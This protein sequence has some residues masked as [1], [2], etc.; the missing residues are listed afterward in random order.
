MRKLLG[1]ILILS[2]VILTNAVP[3]HAVNSRINWTE[4]ELAFIEEHPVIR[5]GI[6]PQF[7]PFEF[8]DKDG[9]YKGITADYLS[10]IQERTGIQF[11]V[12]KGLTWPEAYDM[13]LS[14]GIDVLPAVSK[15]TERE[16]YFLFSDPYYYFKRVIVTR[17]TDTEISGIEDLESQTIAVQRNSSHHSYLLSYPK[18]NLSLYDS[19]ETALTAVANGT[20]RAFVGNLAT[21]NYLI[22]SNGLTNLKF[23]AFEAEKQQALYFAVR[24]DWP[25]LVGILNKAMDTVTEEEKLS[26]HSKWIDLKQE[27]DYGPMI[28]IVSIIGALVAVVMT[29]SFYWIIRLRKEVR[30][31]ERVQRDLEKAK[32]EA[33]E[34]NE[35]K[36]SFMAR[37]SHEIRTPL[38]A[39][40][41]MAYLLKKTEVS[42][43]QKMYI[44]RITQA[45]TNML[46][47]IND[48]LDFSKIEAG[49]VELEIT[50]F[51]MD[52]VI[53]DVV[54]I[55][56]YKIEEQQIGFK[57]SKDPLVPNWFYGDSKRIEQ[58]LLNILNNAAKF[59]ST[60]EVSLEL[61]LVAK[62][63]EKY[64]LSFSV[65]DTGIG[66]TKEQV[67]KLFEPFTQG[68][69]SINRRFG[70]S[71]LGLSIVKNLVDMMG[72]QI[73]V[74]ST[75]G[76]GS[77]FILHLTLTIDKEKQDEYVKTVSADHF[78][79]VRTLI[80]EKAG[81]SMNLMES[82][83]RALG[84]QCELT[85]S[86]AS[87][88]SML[89]AADGKFAKPFDLLIVDYETPSQGGFQ[90]LESIRNNN[91]IV[92][93]PKTI[94]LLPMMREDLFDR[95]D[96]Y[97]IDIGIGKPIIPSILLNGILDLFSLKAV[98]SQPSENMGVYP[99]KTDKPYTV[100]V[101]EDNKTNQ[102]IAKS[103][104]QQAGM[105][106][107]Q[108]SDGKAAIDLYNPTQ[109]NIDLILMDLHM[110]VMNGYDAA[111]EIRK[112]SAHIP[113]VAMTADVILGVREKCEQSGIHYY[114]S[115]PFDPDRF[116]Q[117]IHEILMKTEDT[118]QA[119][120]ILDQSAGL[121][122]MGGEPKV[123]QQILQEYLEEN[124]ETPKRLS[125]AVFEKRYSDA[126]QII[127]K[128]KSSTGSI[129]AKTLHEI[130]VKLQ[131]ALEHREESEI[132]LLLK[133]FSNMFIRLLEEITA[134][135]GQ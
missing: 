35:F 37:M 73:Q 62:E 106:V 130:S 11:E 94:M 8:I 122:N 66:M 75:P 53:Q 50:S 42:L 19:V 44:D 36:S 112:I 46:S 16:Q 48:I 33:D 102:L 56:S 39:I 30:M 68:D 15:T 43:T 120:P 51:S 121:R 41:G 22:R 111:K 123:Y 52:Q 6:D 79:S 126:A 115:K 88:L 78:K 3:C 96:E 20:E 125:L 63:N 12:V 26:I 134:Y 89:E 108:A 85:T 77:T 118:A 92:K 113:I 97:G 14:G 133:E 71:G 70:G 60:G 18:T 110:P 45:S 67:D 83:L 72:G 104:L 57:L 87:A 54:N 61:R 90:F 9:E 1:L 17:D 124:G 91:S 84:I 31:R 127:H 58:I 65:K 93:K 99:G 10:L 49:K 98:S 129:G 109:D 64:H 132:S 100:L 32:K 13:A 29:V 24:K 135:L 27:T 105:E 5:L 4:E 95:L 81:A 23:I 74:F 59:T 69:S 128:V 47:I 114:I 116:I 28:R 117:T 76:E 21:T 101:V 86:Q 119:A 103:L 107:I 7:V 131:K 34:A 55:V 80:L 38:N 82:Y 40:T 2:G 25:D